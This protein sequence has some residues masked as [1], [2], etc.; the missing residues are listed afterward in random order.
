VRRFP[1]SVLIV[2]VG[3]LLALSLAFHSIYEDL[4]KSAVLRQLGA[5]MGMTEAEVTGRLTE[6]AVPLLMAFGTLWYVFRYLKREFDAQL[7]ATLKPSLNIT[8]DPSNPGCVRPNTVMSSRV[9][10]RLPDGKIEEFTHSSPCTYYRA[11]VT[12]TGS[13]SIPDC[14]GILVSIKRD[15]Q[16]IAE[17]ENVSLPFAPSEKSDASAKRIDPSTPEYLDFLIVTHQNRIVVA[18]SGFYFPSSY[19]FDNMFLKQGRYEF[20]IRVSSPNVSSADLD[21]TLD[22]TGDWKNA[23]VLQEGRDKPGHDDV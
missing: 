14:F 9:A 19:D 12:A 17:G 22:W 15:G 4:L 20:K 8:F 5:V 21:V 11:K 10:L 23:T 3:A 16:T 18:S 7:A 6:V 2:F 1:D 13:G